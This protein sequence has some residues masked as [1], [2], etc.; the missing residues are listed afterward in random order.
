MPLLDALKEPPPDIGKKLNGNEVANA[1]L[2]NSLR[3]ES[4]AM[5]PFTVF[6]PSVTEMRGQ[7]GNNYTD[8]GTWETRDDALCG[9]WENW[10]GALQNCWEVY[11]SG[12]IWT[13]QHINGVG[14]VTAQW[15]RGNP[16]GL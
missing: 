8:S 1:L 2:G 4:S 11:R 9:R 13:L 14:Q 12:S 16:A 7:R 15:V 10:R 6:F 5:G 3:A